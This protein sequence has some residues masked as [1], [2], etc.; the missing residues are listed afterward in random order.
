MPERRSEEGAAAAMEAASGEGGRKAGRDLARRI[1]DWARRE[2]LGPGTRLKEEALAAAFGLSRSPVRRALAALAEEG[3]VAHQARRGYSL[4]VPPE[5][6]PAAELPEQGEEALALRIADEHLSGLVG[7][8]LAE[9]ALLRRYGVP[10]A[11]LQRAM[12]RLLR[13]GLI[14][15]RT[16]QGWEFRPLLR[17]PDAYLQAFRFRVVIEPAALLEPG[18]RLAPAVIAR[19]R[20]EQQAL[21]AGGWQA[22]SRAE[23]HRIGA[24]FHVALMAGSGNPFFVE[25][26][27][28]VNAMRRLI[29]YRVHPDQARLR[30][31]CTEHL[32][33]LEL[34][35]GGDL[36][37][38]SAFLRVHLMG[39][40]LSK[41]SL[42]RASLAAGQDSPAR[43][44]AV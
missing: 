26:I 22:A 30:R 2:K 18:Y 31:I 6:L 19:L 44:S 24:A 8:R 32:R 41:E 3:L 43:T 33:I 14:E 9:S 13:E 35:E 17:S 10:R 11:L 34:I 1:L 16:G 23:T 21:L 40:R 42:I 12:A 39:S 15:K 27:R 7:P 4:R 5:A 28:Q 38:A 20:A 37:A 36:E 29:E 25:A